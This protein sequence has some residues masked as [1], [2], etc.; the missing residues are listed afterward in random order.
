MLG[1]LHARRSLGGALMATRRDVGLAD[2]PRLW[3]DVRAFAQAVAAGR[4][5]EALAL[6]R[7]RLL[8]GIDDDWAVAARDAFDDLAGEPAVALVHV[9]VRRL[10]SG[11]V[12]VALLK[13][14][15]GIGKT[16]LAPAGR[17]IK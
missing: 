6:R 3:T 7:G 8:E 11:G 2:D 16:T 1:E 9:A 10:A 12:G 15:G 5:E 4:P 14:E 13:G 17:R